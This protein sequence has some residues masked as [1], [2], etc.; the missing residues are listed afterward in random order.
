MFTR[1]KVIPI[2]LHH[3]AHVQRRHDAGGLIVHVHL[4]HFGR[5][6]DCHIKLFSRL[7]FQRAIDL[8]AIKGQIPQVCTT[9]VDA[10]GEQTRHA[11]DDLT[12]LHVDFDQ[13]IGK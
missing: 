3:F 12:G 1:V 2:V 7:V 13:A 5:I 4:R 10:S 11:G 9:A 8:A 6:K